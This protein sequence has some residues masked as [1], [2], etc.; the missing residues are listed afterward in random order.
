MLWHLVKGPIT[1]PIFVW[2]LSNIS[3]SKT[4]ASNQMKMGAKQMGYLISAI[5]HTYDIP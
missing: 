5:M 1:L 3:K 2:I 4:G